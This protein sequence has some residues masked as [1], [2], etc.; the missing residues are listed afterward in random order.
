MVSGKLPSA[1]RKPLMVSPRLP[2]AMDKRLS[3]PEAAPRSAAVGASVAAR[4]G[5]GFPG[6]SPTWAR[7]ERMVA[8]FGGI[9]LVLAVCGAICVA[10][11]KYWP[12]ESVGSLRVVGRVSLSSRHSIYLVRAGE[13]VLLIGTGS[14]GAPVC[15]AS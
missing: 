4:P 13:R 11:R 8:G 9:T 3:V 6:V 12:R 14:Q 5:R 1:S 15:S 10:A 2:T 7:H